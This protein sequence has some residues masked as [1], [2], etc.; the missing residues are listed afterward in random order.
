MTELSHLWPSPEPV[1]LGHWSG[2]SICFQLRDLAR[3][4]TL[5][6][7]VGGGDPLAGRRLELAALRAAAGGDPLG[8][9]A[10]CRAYGEAVR[11]AIRAVRD[12]GR[13]GGRLLGSTAGK[14]LWLDVLL[15]RTN[16]GFTAATA[17]GIVT[18]EAVTADQWLQLES[19]AYAEHP[20]DWLRRLLVPPP[21]RKAPLRSWSE[22]IG[23]VMEVRGWTFEEV[24]SLYLS[25]WRALGGEEPGRLTK[26]AQ[27]AAWYRAVTEL[28]R[29][30]MAQ[31]ASANG[32]GH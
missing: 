31:G 10:E 9:S 7:T 1:A 15:S 22:A 5:E 29:R 3:L 25:Q 4:E 23:E 27:N 20:A 19:I 30:V 21:R 2:L 13:A 24:G 32:R 11:A 17:A 6:R 12:R 8:A 18:D 28:E 16:P 14:V 26:T